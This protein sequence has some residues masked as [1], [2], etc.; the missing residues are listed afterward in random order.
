MLDP[1]FADEIADGYEFYSI[2]RPKDIGFGA[3]TDGFSILFPHMKPFI[4]PRRFY[5]EGN[6]DPRDAL[7]QGES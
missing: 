4:I 5:G 6:P 2:D 7:V 1:A 3:T